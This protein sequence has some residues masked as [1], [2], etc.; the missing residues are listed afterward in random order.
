MQS[1]LPGVWRQ[2]G[3][4]TAPGATPELNF[5]PKEGRELVSGENFRVWLIRLQE[6]GHPHNP[7]QLLCL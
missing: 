1:S 5:L 7:K 6:N 3:E 4:T 2:L